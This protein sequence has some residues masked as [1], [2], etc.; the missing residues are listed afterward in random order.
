M[1]DKLLKINKQLDELLV[2]Q[3]ELIQDYISVTVE[4]ETH[5]KNGFIS[6]AKARYIQGSHSVSRNCLFSEDTV[7]DRTP[8]L[9]VIRET[10][11]L[12]LSDEDEAK[13][14]NVEP[15]SYEAPVLSVN[16]D[17]KLEG[18]LSRQFG[19]LPSSSLKFAKAEFRRCLEKTMERAS[20]I[21]QSLA[22]RNRYQILMNE[23]AEIS[24]NSIAAP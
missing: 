9:T 15:V 24:L 2:K 16:S 22:I 12:D 4:C 10:A 23:K 5:Q 21:E 7:E 17:V 14:E 3:L 1:D 13:I 20:I 19:V 6:M 8:L 11:K 18:Q